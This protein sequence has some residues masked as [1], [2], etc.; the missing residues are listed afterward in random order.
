MIRFKASKIITGFKTTVNFI[1]SKI[2]RYGKE[3]E[4][5]AI[6]DLNRFLSD[7][8]LYV[9][10]CGLFVSIDKGYLAASPDGI[11]GKDG[12]VEVKCPI[13]CR[14]NNIEDLA[15]QDISFCLQYDET[16]DKLRL[17]RNHNYYYQIQ[18]QL[19]I[20]NR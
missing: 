2:F 11:V 9:E 20:A 18:G 1:I 7:E 4:K 8:V 5:N 14:D 10:E 12:L 19:H 6:K 17:K 3:N 15:R 16:E 13:I